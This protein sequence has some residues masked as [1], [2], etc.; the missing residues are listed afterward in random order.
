MCGK[1]FGRWMLDVVVDTYAMYRVWVLRGDDQRP[2]NPTPGTMIFLFTID[3]CC[4]NAFLEWPFNGL[5][6]GDDERL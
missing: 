2:F 6:P 1:S 5:A 3:K 4:L